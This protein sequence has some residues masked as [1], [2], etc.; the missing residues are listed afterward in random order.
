[1]N[2]TE[3]NAVVR[4]LAGI[5]RAKYAHILFVERQA[6]IGEVL[7]IVPYFESPIQDLTLN[8]VRDMLDIIQHHENRIKSLIEG[9]NKSL[10]SMN[11]STSPEGMAAMF[12]AIAACE[13]MDSNRYK[14]FRRAVVRLSPT[15]LWSK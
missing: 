6:N 1:M 2:A 13:D 10:Q 3:Y 9:G 12:G 14:Y 8:D 15:E 5:C 11:L 4:E 7:G